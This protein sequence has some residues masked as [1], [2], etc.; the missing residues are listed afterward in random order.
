MNKLLCLLLFAPVLAAASPVG[1]R[2]Y[3]TCVACHGT[4]GKP[5]GNALPKLAGQPKE[6]LVASM[7][8]FR[9]GTR[10]ATIMHQISKGYTDQQVEQIAAFLASQKP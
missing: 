6:A 1:E 3:A 8:A 9:D 4:N 7:R 2:L 10:P 5:A